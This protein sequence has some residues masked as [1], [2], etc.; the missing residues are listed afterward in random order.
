MK[1][2]ILVPQMTCFL[3]SHVVSFAK[4][5]ILFLKCFSQTSLSYVSYLRMTY[6]VSH[7][8]TRFCRTKSVNDM[9]QIL[10]QPLANIS[11][12]DFEDLFIKFCIEHK[13]FNVVFPCF[14]NSDFSS[15]RIE[16]LSHLSPNNQ[17]ENDWFR[18]CI[19]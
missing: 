12:C 18:L 16:S 11:Y 13:L 4:V 8:T 17:D 15:C 10:N 19:N 5:Q 3:G 9:E 7:W 2:V 1:D 14:Q 6:Q